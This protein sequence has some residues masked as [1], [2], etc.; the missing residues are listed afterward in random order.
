MRIYII[1]AE[2]S[3]KS[4][5]SRFLSLELGIPAAET[6]RVVMR[7]LAKFHAQQRDTYPDV[8]VV[9]ATIE[10]CKDQ[11]RGHLRMMG[12]MMTKLKPTV[13]IDECTNP[14]APAIIVGVRRIREVQGLADHGYSYMT[15]AVWIRIDRPGHDRKPGDVFE[16]HD[17]PCNYVV[18]NCGSLKCLRER[19]IRIAAE[20]RQRAQASGTQLLS[21]AA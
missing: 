17:M 13:L 8:D 12:T 4:T 19:M 18:R 5:A 16:L 14:Y 21:A 10:Q 20:L 9:A 2:E 15:D 7:E 1:G 3:G 11:F 6:G